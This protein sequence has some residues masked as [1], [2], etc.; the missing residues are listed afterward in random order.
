MEPIVFPEDGPE[1]DL[2]ATVFNLLRTLVKSY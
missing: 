2:L 1:Q